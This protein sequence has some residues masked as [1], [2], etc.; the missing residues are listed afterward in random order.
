MIY[1]SKVT[2]KQIFAHKRNIIFLCAVFLIFSSFPSLLLSQNRQ[3]SFENNLFISNNIEINTDN[4]FL[5]SQDITTLSQN[6]LFL[7]PRNFLLSQDTLTVSP[8]YNRLLDS[9][10]INSTYIAL[11][12]ITQSI[13]YKNYDVNTRDL[14]L[15]YLNNF[16]YDY[17][18]YLQ[19]APGCLTFTLKGL[20]F[21]SRST[22]SEL[23]VAS[24]LSYGVSFGFIKLLKGNVKELR[25]DGS[26]RNSFP[27]GHTTAAFAGASILAK[28]YKDK[29]AWISILG[30]AASSVTGISRIM[31]HRH[32]L[33]D[34]FFGAGL[35]MLS[36]EFSYAL[37]D[38]IF[39]KKE[40]FH[41][42]FNN[43]DFEQNKPS[44]AN[45]FFSY[46]ILLSSSTKKLN[47]NTEYTINNGIGVGIEGAYFFN[48]N[49]G[50]NLRSKMDSYII[51]Y[52]NINSLEDSAMF[53]KS[54]ELGPTFATSICDRWIVGGRL[55]FGL[56]HLDENQLQ[57]DIPIQNQ[58]NFQFS[59]GLYSNIWM[60][61]YTYLRL[62]ADTQF[63]TI[64]V[65]HKKQRFNNLCLG[66]TIGLHF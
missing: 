58:I 18:T 3:F 21:E 10:I 59:C 31:N 13:M 23:I 64:K 44:F 43:S 26:A 28:E 48:N 50:V 35:G 22:W 7:T 29:Y 27:S 45:L 24:A 19:F 46:N 65:E 1:H 6:N 16:L 61:K 49:I 20:G 17:D 14:R 57:D 60:E 40:N 2:I 11:S 30:Y 8:K 34:V 51:D 5:L 52:Q 53:I 42:S 37:T 41:Y 39:N 33:H 12:L 66:V 36:T 38:V 4:N 9:K 62:F 55:G 56:N 15:R 25:P 54:I 32:W 47:D 63:T